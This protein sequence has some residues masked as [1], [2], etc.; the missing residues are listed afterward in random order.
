MSLVAPTLAGGIYQL[1]HLGSHVAVTDTSKHRKM[2]RRSMINESLVP[3]VNTT[4][5]EREMRE[6]V[7]ARPR[8]LEEWMETSH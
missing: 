5:E 3:N 6:E 4:E 2:H 7:P 8:P 1:S